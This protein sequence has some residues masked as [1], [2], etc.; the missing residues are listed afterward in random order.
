[1]SAPHFWFGMAAAKSWSR[2][3][4]KAVRLSVVRLN[5]RFCRALSPFSRIAHQPGDASA[6]D[7]KPIVATFV[8]HARAATRAGSNGHV[9]IFSRVASKRSV[10]TFGRSRLISLG[11]VDKLQPKGLRHV[12]L[13][14]Q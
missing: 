11:I 8:P 3:F 7:G 13:S 12:A 5:R 1:M 4:G 10:L 6:A 14:T 9:R 2:R